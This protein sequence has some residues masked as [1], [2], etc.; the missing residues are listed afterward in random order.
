MKLKEIYTILDRI[1]PFELQEKWDNS[2]LQVGDFDQKIEHIYLCID[3]DEELIDSLPPKSLLITHHPLIFGK[4]TSI[5]YNAYPAKLLVRLIKKDIALI[6][7]HTNFDKTHLN[8]Y[9]AQHVLQVE[10]QCE[11]FICYFEREESFEAIF[12]WVKERFGLTCP[13]YV[14]AKEN[15]KKIALTTGSGGGLLDMVD[16]DLFLTGDIKYHD[17]MKANILGISMIDIGHF[18]SEHYFAQ[19]LQDE[20]KKAQIKAIIASIKNP[21]KA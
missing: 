4:L 12:A 8:R 13:R 18:E 1:S 16:A 11:E 6:S 21:L 17:A 19:C 5:E 2:G 20:L 15:I 10:P 3:L 14:Q 7:M 9:V